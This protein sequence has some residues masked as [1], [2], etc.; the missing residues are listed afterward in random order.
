MVRGAGAYFAVESQ[1]SIHYASNICSGSRTAGQKQIVLTNVLVGDSVQLPHSSNTKTLRRPPAK[2]AAAAHAQESATGI[3]FATGAN[4]YD[5]VT[6]YTGGSQ[7][8][9]VYA[10]GRAYP[11]YLLTFE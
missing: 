2:T 3:E 11:Q 7:I 9:V 10:H 8:F 4:A 5:S 1:Y 6:G